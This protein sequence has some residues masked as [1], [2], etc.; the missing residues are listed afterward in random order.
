MRPNQYGHTRVGYT[1]S[2]DLGWRD[3]MSCLGYPAEYDAWTEKEQ[4]NYERGRL[5]RANVVLAFPGSRAGHQF[6]PLI[7]KAERVVG[8]Y[9][10]DEH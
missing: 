7:R 1:A 9:F 5:R 3:H 8:P 6:R 2:S 10:P 4:R